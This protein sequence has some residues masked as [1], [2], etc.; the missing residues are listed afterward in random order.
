MGWYMA[1]VLYILG[2]RMAWDMYMADLESQD[3]E[4]VTLPSKLAF[5][6]TVALWPFIELHNLIF[7]RGESTHGSE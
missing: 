1:T 5:I 2:G 6:G 3:I 4:V 7:E